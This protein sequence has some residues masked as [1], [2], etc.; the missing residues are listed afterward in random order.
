MNLGITGNS[1]RYDRFAG[2]GPYERPEYGGGTVLPDNSDITQ[3]S[4]ADLVVTF[5]SV[6]EAMVSTTEASTLANL[7]HCAGRLWREVTGRGVEFK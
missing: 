4:T 2:A 7:G 3:A 5:C 6:M 1:Q